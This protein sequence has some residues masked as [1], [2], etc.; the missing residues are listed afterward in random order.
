[1]MPLHTAS[2][3]DAALAPTFA[4]LGVATND[5]LPALSLSSMDRASAMVE[6]MAA[7]TKAR[8]QRLAAAKAA[9]EAKHT[10]DA[11]AK[12]EKQRKAENAAR[13]EAEAAVVDKALA[14]SRAKA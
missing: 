7:K 6:R 1:M 3:A 10:A 14:A 2:D 9:A 5:W 8:Q 11:A 4:A 13:R 12:A